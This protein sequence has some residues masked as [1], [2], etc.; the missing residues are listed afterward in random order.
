MSKTLEEMIEQLKQVEEITLVE[1]LGLS[2]EDLVDRFRDII[3]D[4]PDKFALELQQFFEDDDE[5]DQTS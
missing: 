4:N 1:M 3:E 5:E 2:S